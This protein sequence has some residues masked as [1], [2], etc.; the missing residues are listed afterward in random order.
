MTQPEMEALLVKMFETGNVVSGRW[1]N[2][3]RS[4]L[5]DFGTPTPVAA[6]AGGERVASV[7]PQGG[8]APDCPAALLWEQVFGPGI[9]SRRRDG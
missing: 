9:Y 6:A 7:W 1:C 8:H 2:V 4:D 3:C 5:S